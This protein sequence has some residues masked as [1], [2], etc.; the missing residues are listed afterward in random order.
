MK[1]FLPV[2]DFSPILI[3]RTLADVVRTDSG[4]A[5][6]VANNGRKVL[7]YCSLRSQRGW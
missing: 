5:V 6:S 3:P 2:L 1:I 4:E 7:I